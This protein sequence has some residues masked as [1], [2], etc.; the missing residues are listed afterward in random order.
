M[1][2][3]TN[4]QRQYVKENI[5]KIVVEDVDRLVEAFENSYIKDTGLRQ[6]RQVH[7]KNYKNDGVAEV[8]YEVNPTSDGGYWSSSP[9]PV[10][11]RPRKFVN[12]EA[13]MFTYPQKCTARDV[14]SDEYPELDEDSEEFEEKVEE[15]Y[16]K[17]KN[18]WRDMIKGM[19]LRDSISLWSH[20]PLDNL[21]IDV[22][23]R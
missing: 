2:E 15:Q 4:K 11:I 19:S 10:Y 9:H 5:G 14:V 7:L 21:E 16:K 3:T 18:I 6:D 8:E 1:E 13:G 17:S 12:K 23:Y 22:E 20:T